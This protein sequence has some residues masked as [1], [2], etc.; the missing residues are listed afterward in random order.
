L[1]QHVIWQSLMNSFENSKTLM[2]SGWSGAGSQGS[3]ARSQRRRRI[4]KLPDCLL[5]ANCDWGEKPG[6]DF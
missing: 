4:A 5:F 2:L 6:G 3:G 1:M